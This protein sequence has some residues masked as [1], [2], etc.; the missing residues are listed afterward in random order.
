ML[1]VY[2]LAAVIFL[3]LGGGRPSTPSTERAVDGRGPV[4][5]IEFLTMQNE[6]T[7][8]DQFAG[9]PLVI[10]FFASWCEPCRQ[11]MPDFERFHQEFGD[12]ITVLGLAVEGARP[13][14]GMVEE[15]GITFPTGLDQSDILVDLGGVGMPTTVFVS[16]QGVQ[17]ETHSG[18]LTFDQIV[19][20]AE[21]H[22]G[23]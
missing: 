4:H 18:V 22:F 1:S 17:L 3:G 15:T 14:R 16:A 5:E 13:A 12:D 11:E 21:E 19:D 20:R 7:T 2:V 23:S 10:N 9:Q 6:P 8:M